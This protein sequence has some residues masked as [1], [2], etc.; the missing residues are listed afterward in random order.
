[1]IVATITR[2]RPSPH[3]LFKVAPRRAHLRCDPQ[4]DVVKLPAA[5]PG[6]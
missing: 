6:I 5:S 4:R 2:A 3:V 1:M